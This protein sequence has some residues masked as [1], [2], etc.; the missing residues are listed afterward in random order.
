M[1]DSQALLQ[2]LHQTLGVNYLPRF[3]AMPEAQEKEPIAHAGPPP[4]LI[5]LN[6][7]E[8]DQ[9]LS[10]AGQD[11]FE[12]IVKAMGLSTDEVW[13]VQANQQSFTDVLNRFRL[14]KIESP[15]VVL[16]KDPEIFDHLQQTGTHSWAECFSIAEMIKN[17]NLKKT[18]WRILQYFLK[19]G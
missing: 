15:V 10:P 19:K 3:Q 18:T 11:V 5:F 7:D 13:W 12:K 4:K 14:L 9:T 2:Y 6:F 1:S 8:N 16:K 17:P